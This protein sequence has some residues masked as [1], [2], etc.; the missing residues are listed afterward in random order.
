LH[1][2][3]VS[4]FGF[5]NIILTLNMTSEII[6]IGDELLIGQVINTNASW[7]AKALNENGVDVRQI[8]SVSDT[9]G[10][11]IRAMQE[12][13]ERAD[14]I[15]IT[16]G[17]GP[18]HD[19]IT[20]DILC[21]YFHTELVEDEKVLENIYGFFQRKGLALT[22]LN[23][24]QALVPK[25]S[26]VINNPIGTAPGLAFHKNGKLFVAMPGVPYEMKHIMQTFVLPWLQN[27]YPGNIILHKTILT[28]G[29][30]ESFLA[31]NIADWVNDLPR[32]IK[33]AY[34]P[35]PGI[36]RLRLSIKGNKRE[37]MTKLLNN[38]VEKLMNLIPEYFWGFDDEKLEAVV[39]EILKKQGKSICTAES[40]T[41]GYIAHRI[42]GIPGSSGWFKGSVVA[43]DNTIKKELLKVPEE[44][45]E[46][47]GAVSREVV[48]KMAMV[49]CRL[50][51]TDYA[52]SVSG[53]AGPDGG[54]ADKPVGTVWIAIAGPD[55]L[56]S[57][58]FL[59]GDE[60]DR[61]I[62]RAG[63]AALGFFRSVL[64]Q[65]EGAG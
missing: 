58:K 50:L 52:I 1:I 27:N 16:G 24:K 25:G 7:M 23:R 18:T 33:L 13:E 21:E 49:A 28:Q 37:A 62:V 3:K 9:A 29:I 15:L 51:S 39:G 53:I 2:A 63:T 45:L 54:T 42:T 47:H 10:E 36:V 43:Y 65:K 5:H 22:E 14:L 48:E 60:R 32:E 4:T 8:T 34:L 61:N 64:L 46:K 30:G 26:T 41:G 59:F 20:K 17:L 55:I 38:E 44:M 31:A 19:D 12:A 40:C 35:S 56:V 6:S 57:K 11:I